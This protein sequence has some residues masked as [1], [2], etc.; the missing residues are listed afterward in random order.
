[1]P[2]TRKLQQNTVLISGAS[3]AGPALALWLV[4]YGFAVTLVE[5]AKE[6]RP[7]VQAVDFKGVTH[8]TVL[9][10]MGILE[11][12]RQARFPSNGDGIIV[13][14]KGRKVAT[15]PS[16]FSS[17]EIEIARGDLARILYEH[18]AAKCE[19]IFNDS[20]TSLCENADGVEVTFQRSVPRVFDLVIGADGIHSN[21]RRLAFG[22]ESDYVHFLGYYYA[23][24]KI[25]CAVEDEDLMYNEPGR[26]ASTGGPKAPAF[27]VFASEPLQYERDN[28][29]QQQRLLAN[30]YRGGAWQIPALMEGLS[31]A[32]EFYMDSV[33]RVT[34]DRY[35]KGRIALL[36]D[37]AYGNTL[38]GFGTG[39]AIV[40]AYVLAGEL[41]R[42]RGEYSI[43]YKQYERK[44]RRYATISQKVN[45]GKLLA[46]RTR[47]GLYARN[48]M[49]TVA[50]LFKGLI[51]LMDH[52][53]SDIALEDYAPEA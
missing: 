13:D 11:E 36:G 27:F 22:S 8:H 16:E 48:R 2:E 19:Y 23:L 17:G 49:F 7:G 53:A 33:S 46:P 1:M 6:V 12:V 5:K 29:E 37:S 24:A 14:A 44:F 47:L 4:R 52:F 30:A 50:P 40:G 43:A 21:V 3:I 20:I 10:G 32:T 26:M 18:T 31:G 34:I 9:E 51:K 42:A 35:S 25:P 45:S 15:V 41:L 28:L 39:L 38:G